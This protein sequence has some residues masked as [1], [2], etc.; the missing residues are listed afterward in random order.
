MADVHTYHVAVAG[1]DA[2][3]HNC[4]SRVPGGVE[5]LRDDARMGTDD[6]LD[7]ATNFLGSDYQDMGRGR[8]LS[9]D[10]VRQVRMTDA[11]LAHR[12]QDPHINFETYEQPIG[13]GVRSGPPAENIH[14]FLPEEPGWH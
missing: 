6:A 7:T 9:K 10:G 3:V 5:N 12:R 2:L 8:F 13:P 1:A 4:S 11:D 14:I